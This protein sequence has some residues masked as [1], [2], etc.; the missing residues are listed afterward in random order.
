MTV[1]HPLPPWHRAL[2]RWLACFIVLLLGPLLLLSLDHFFLGRA[3]AA[4]T[5][6]GVTAPGSVTVSLVP[7]LLSDGPLLFS[8]LTTILCV[9]TLVWTGWLLAVRDARG[10]QT[11]RW[12]LPRV[13]RGFLAFWSFYAGINKVFPNQ[14]LPLDNVSLL[15]PFGDFS[16][17]GVVWNYFG[18]GQSYN[19]LNGLAECSVAV[20]LCFRKTTL[21]GAALGFSMFVN[22]A[23]QNIAYDG[24]FKG[25]SLLLVAL[26]LL[27]TLFDAPR[28][29]AFIWG[30]RTVP[31]LEPLVLTTDI[32]RQRRLGRLK[33]I[34]VAVVASLLVVGAG[35]DYRRIQTL[36][37]AGPLDG[38]HLAVSVSRDG[39]AQPVTEM[40][41]WRY[42]IVN[43]GGRSGGVLTVAGRM[44]RRAFEIDE[45][46]Q[47]IQQHNPYQG[48][49]TRTA[50]AN[51][52]LPS[53]TYRHL[54]NWEPV[55]LHYWWDES[56]RLK[57][58]V[59]HPEHPLVYTLEKVERRFILTERGFHL[60]NDAAFNL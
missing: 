9:A 4:S 60:V 43:A 20:L 27:L 57:L 56:G 29:L 18:F 25:F 22:G 7:P 10:D 5:V 19:L 41:H 37:T 38:I 45:T 34:L 14:Y 21:P 54:L 47:R 30:T 17:L 6:P 35:L 44:S 23:A 3:A 36:Q 42:F 16:L 13:L 40:N 49:V 31:A 59:D 33:A 55:P 1:E 12:L 32:T 58:H 39:V 52:S 15:T 28:W 46:L 50:L 8:A 2:L 53:Q 11:L 26:F 48:D 24:P 51:G